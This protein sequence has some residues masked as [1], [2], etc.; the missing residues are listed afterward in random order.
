[1]EDTRLQWMKDL[2]YRFLSI[3]VNDEAFDELITDENNRAII[4]NLFSA[5]KKSQRCIFFYSDTVEEEIERDD[6]IEESEEIPKPDISQSS[7]SIESVSEAA[8][9]SSVEKEKEAVPKSEKDADVS[10]E[11]SSKRDSDEKSENTGENDATPRSNE[12]KTTTTLMLIVK[13]TK[14]FL[15]FNITRFVSGRSYVYFHLR[16]SEP[17][18]KT[19]TF[20]E[21]NRVMP[22]YFQLG[23]LSQHPIICID[24]MITLLYNPLFEDENRKVH[25]SV[26]DYQVDD[27]E[28]SVLSSDFNREVED[29]IYSTKQI[30]SQIEKPF[31]FSLPELPENISLE[32]LAQE[33]EYVTEAQEIT[34]E[35]N[36]VLRNLLHEISEMNPPESGLLE[37][38]HFWRAQELKLSI[39]SDQMS[40]ATVLRTIKILKF[41]EIDI[42][43]FE[44]SMK[45]IEDLLNKV[46][47]K[48]SYLSVLKRNAEYLLSENSKDDAKK[49][50]FDTFVILRVAWVQSD[51]FNIDDNMCRLLKGISMLL[52]NRVKKEAR[53][54]SL[55]RKPLPQIS[56]IVKE[57]VEILQYWK[58][59]Y[60]D[61]SEKIKKYGASYWWR[62]DTRILFDEIDHVVSVCEDI[63][64]VSQVLQEL[65]N[66]FNTNLRFFVEDMEDLS[67]L[68]NR[69]FGM[70]S[71][72]QFADVDA[73]DPKF[74]SEWHRIIQV[75]YR[76][77]RTFEDQMK[78]FIGKMFQTSL[79][80]ENAYI[81]SKSFD[82][83]SISP[84]IREFIL[85]S[86]TDMLKQFIKEISETEN[87]FL[88]YE[89]HP[90]K[91]DVIPETAS[92]V[93]WVRDLLIKISKP[94]SKISD[95]L[96]DNDKDVEVQVRFKKVEKR[97]LSY[98]KEK[99]E[100]WKL[101]S[102]ENLNKFLQTNLLKKF[103]SYQT[104]L[105]NPTQ[106][107]EAMMYKV[108]FPLYLEEVSIEAR[109]FEELGY[110]I[111]LFV[112]N[113]VLQEKSFYKQRNK[114]KFISEELSDIFSDLKKEEISILRSPIENVVSVLDLGVNQI[115]WESTDV[116]EFLK[117]AK[118]AID[119]FRSLV[120]QM[121][122]I[123]SE[124]DNK[125]KSLSKCDLFQF[126]KIEDSIPTC[127]VFFEEAKM[128]MDRKVDYMVNIYVSLEP[129]LKKVE[130]ISCK[131]STGKAAQMKDYYYACE[132][133]IL[134][135]LKIMMITNLEYFRDEILE[136]FIFPYVETAFKSKDE[137][138]TSSIIR[139]KLIF[140]N[141]MTSAIE[142]TRKLVRWL[143]GTCIE[144]SPFSYTEKKAQMEFSYYLDLSIHP[145]IKKLVLETINS[146][147]IY[148]DKQNSQ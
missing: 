127:E 136:N 2:I 6:A 58:K 88:T 32:D 119:I 100:A 121:K 83:F 145:Q 12:G 16:K 139:I 37:E 66:I 35:W 134:Q 26:E 107:E 50:L 123:V 91:L 70:T 117:K 133:R 60:M 72:I 9:E 11:D 113:V 19:E 1:M 76:D 42:S 17:I 130:S 61:E 140:V 98:R 24:K 135:S 144:S 146:F 52:R 59:L 104:K 47:D 27:N 90:P 40:H 31:M 49:I 14:L 63:D 30:I 101:S 120:Q 4:L 65:Y 103:Q 18:P 116:P 8:S 87:H 125:I 148:V 38:I 64:R 126:A 96:T 68:Q 85:K 137:L 82:K 92:A 54:N 131:T 109:I 132:E 62:F 93:L 53:I 78:L 86:R 77:V 33:T 141:F 84:S 55:F 51:Y 29:F 106:L 95:L 23:C 69:I 122:N 45:N 118:Q 44:T 97:I 36:T 67:S 79:T 57:S 112:K 46:T 102:H 73:F 115:L 71:I 41:A 108:N 138:I 143:D 34:N 25:L 43:T 81:L 80:W 3:H 142:S 105:I 94:M 10:D 114:I 5:S 99:Y 128:K 13:K 75:F 129:L 28:M 124:I 48:M 20:E 111:P 147:F 7:R 21:A 89:R 110:E 39:C 56:K 74:K 15:I 22:Q